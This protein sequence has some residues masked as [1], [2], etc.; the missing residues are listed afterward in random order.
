MKLE[1]VLDLLNSFE[2]NSF[3]KILSTIVENSPKLAKEV[4]KIVASKDIKNADSAMISK[5]FDLCSSDYANS[6]T[7]ALQDTENQIDILVDIIIRDGNSIMSREWLHRLYEA[8]IKKLNLKLNKFKK[9]IEDEKSEIEEQRLRDYLIYKSCVETA[10]NNDTSNNLDKKVTADEVAILNTLTKSLELSQ[11]EVKLINYSV[12]PV[13]KLDIETIINDLKNIGLVFYSKKTSI[14]YIPDEI[15]SLVRKV[16]GK[17]VADKY[18]RRVL[19]QLKEPQINQ[20]SKKHNID[21]RQPLEIKIKAIINDGIALSGVLLQDIFK[22]G[23][24]VSEKKAVIDTF[25]EKNLGIE[26]S[27]RTAEDKVKSLINHFE[28]IE[29]DEKVGI[30]KEGYESLLSDMKQTLPKLNDIIRQEFEL[31]DEEVLKSD[32]LLD[33]NIKPRDILDLLKDED[34]TKF[35]DAKSIKSRG[36]S[37][38][39]ILFAYKDSENLYLESYNDIAFRNLN[40]LKEN[41][42]NIKEA[43]LGVK[44]EELTRIIFTKLGFNV[45]EK[46]RKEINNAKN[47]IDIVINL[48]DNEIIVVE[49][50]TSKESGYNKF[51]AVSR[52]IKAYIDQSTK[53]GKKVIKSLLI[54]PEFSDDF[55]KECREEFELNLSLITSNSLLNILNGLKQSKLKQLPYKLLL[56]DVVINDELI[57]KSIMK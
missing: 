49:C 35:C 48:G 21:W 20:I 26:P 32:L 39:N 43:E 37:I 9:D 6:I 41:G 51:S 7:S 44:F 45:D 5:V 18:F 4:E 55:Q 29:K 30:S 8:E 47:Q 17:E 24:K 50:K 13:K 2:K 14:C 23:V 31:Q 54:A 46:L 42:I 16:R 10:Y 40:S 27:G 56:R 38:S 22:D 33:Y 52:Q 25:I 15:V 57:I 11:E 3:L 53:S 34:L 36:D 19:K 12:I 1:K 28:E